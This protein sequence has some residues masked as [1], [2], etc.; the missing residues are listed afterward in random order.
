MRKFTTRQRLRYAFDNTMAKGPIALIAYLF[1]FSALIIVG[2]AAFAFLTQT[3]GMG[4]TPIL[5][6]GSDTPIPFG[7]FIWMG[8]MR[9]LDSGTMGG[10]TGSPW[11]LGSMLAVTLGGI[12]IVST[13]IGLLTTGIE[14]KL[15][16]LRKG[17]S[18][19]VENDHTVIV[20]WSQQVFTIVRELVVANENRKSACV[21]ILAD[22]DKVEMEDEIR[23]RCGDTRTTRVVCR[24]GNPASMQ[25]LD[26]VNA[27]GARAVIVL[28]PEASEPDHTIIK[29]L[30]AL[31][32]HPA[33]RPGV[34]Q[35]VAELSDESNLDVAKMIG[36]GDVLPVLSSAVI[37]RITV[38]ACRQ[39]GLSIVFTE[40][41]DF[42]GDEIYF[43]EEPGLVGKTFGEALLAYEESAVIGLYRRAAEGATG[44]AVQLNP[45]MGSR[46]E[47]GDQ[48]IAISRDDDTVKLS[49]VSPAI[50]R[51]AIRQLPAEAPV[52]E[53][54]LILGWNERGAAIARELDT[55]V[56]PGSALVIVAGDPALAEPVSRLAGD[57]K[58]LQVSFQPGDT[59]DRSTLEHLAVPGYQHIIISDS[60]TVD[61]NESSDPDARTLLTLLHLRTFAGQTEG[62]F[63][64]VTEM[65]DPRNQEL[66]R[67]TGADDFIVSDRLVGLMLAQLAENR[68]LAAVFDD[69]F[70]ADGSELHLKP[71]EQYVA[72]G[73]PVSFYTVVEAAK[74]RDEVAVGYR[75]AAEAADPGRS[76]GVHL[77]PPKS[78][79]VKFGPG[80]RVI[81]LA[82]N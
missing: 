39:S 56:A 57:L 79:P 35:I 69:L 27:H 49:G 52:A 30:L 61:G 4:D 5:P 16:D 17:R 7:Q 40:L 14:G 10:D 60:R 82:E 72:P 28:A 13:L 46:I 71:A 53:R 2:I 51:E 74:V 48:V 67:V 78:V 26:M 62:P 9:T 25:D 47:A 77:N 33:R 65:L 55:F 81:V 21:A 66:A 34:D 8:L 31:T 64:I 6:N 20:G 73:R 11:F 58:H 38:Q 42:D 24:S 12:F 44:R 18:P 29:S 50:D 3:T 32:N 76:Y 45:L 15:D 59:T 19:I 1:V 36:G 23:A 75:L 43:Q 80:D 63:S 68:Q 37:A 41:L 54:I 70:D 22:R